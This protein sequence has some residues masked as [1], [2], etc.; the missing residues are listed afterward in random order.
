MI[1]YCKN[2]LKCSKMHSSAD[3]ADPADPPEVVARSA[4]R[5]PLPHAPGARMTAVYTNSIKLSVEIF[6]KS[7]SFSAVNFIKLGSFFFPL[8]GIGAKKGLSVSIN[9]LS[10]LIDLNVL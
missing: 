5:T 4:A 6:F 9:N 3:P 7:A 8:I 1:C 10:S 2:H